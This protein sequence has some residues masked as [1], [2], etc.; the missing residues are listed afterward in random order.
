[1]Y[2]KE[3]VAHYQNVIGYNEFYVVKGQQLGT[4]TDEA[5]GELQDDASKGQIGAAFRKQAKSKKANKVLL[6]KFGIAVA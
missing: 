4:A 1:M 6:T 5:L 2:R 3:K